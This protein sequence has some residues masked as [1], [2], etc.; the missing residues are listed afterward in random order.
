MYSIRKSITPSADSRN[1]CNE[2]QY[3]KARIEL[4]EL[5]AEADEDVTNGRVSPIQD[6]FNNLRTMLKGR[7]NETQNLRA[8]TADIGENLLHV[9]LQ[10]VANR[11]QRGT[12]KAPE[13]GTFP[14]FQTE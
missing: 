3:I 8:D 11:L 4:L 1:H 12:K 5:L 7:Y 2:Y 13:Y 10:L 6:T 9:L 14:D